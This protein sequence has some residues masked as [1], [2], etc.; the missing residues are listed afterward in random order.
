MNKFIIFVL[1]ITFIIITFDNVLKHSSPKENMKS[2]V[3]N[4]NIEKIEN[5]ENIE[6]IENIKK[7]EN[8]DKIIE[9]IDKIIENTWNDGDTFY[10]NF[11]IYIINLT[12]TLEGIRRHLIISKKKEKLFKRASFYKGV[13]GKSYNY[14]DEL[15]ANVIA[16]YWDIGKWKGEKSRIIKM[17]KG[18]IGI[19]LSNYYLWKKIADT[20]KN[21]I[22]LEDDAIN[23]DANF[24]NYLKFF[25]SKLPKDW[26]I[27][28]LGFWLHRG[29]D[30]QQI[31]HHIYKVKNFVLLH[32][33]IMTP[34]CA[35]KLLEFLPID[36]P[37]D[38]WLSQQSEKINIYRHNYID[39]NNQS[40]L[41]RQK[42]FLKQIKNTNNW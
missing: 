7:I 24:D 9:N 17:D 33:L 18:E 32:A 35:K 19:I 40:R 36:M 1:T 37:L 12:Q 4:K 3:N 5:K 25:M 23:I 15:K 16:E 39:S 42:R 30:G 21:T 10:D 13:Y 27:F 20:Q 6:N 28:L 26:D 8:I 41:I 2:L 22:I 31:N 11:N 38:T 14:N 29:D 34:S